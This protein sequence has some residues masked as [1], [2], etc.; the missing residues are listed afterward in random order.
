MLFSSVGISVIVL[1]LEINP[2]IFF[3]ISYQTRQFLVWDVCNEAI[4][5]VKIHSI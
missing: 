1:L 5:I 3:L 4:T 2:L